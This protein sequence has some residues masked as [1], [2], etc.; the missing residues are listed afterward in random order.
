VKNDQM[1]FCI[2]FIRFNQNSEGFDLDEQTE[3]VLR[4][5][6]DD[7]ISTDNAVED[8]IEKEKL[9]TVFKPLS[10]NS[11]FYPNK[12]IQVN[13][14]NIKDKKKLK[15]I[16]NHIYPLRLAEIL[17]NEKPTK[18]DFEFLKDLHSSLFG[19]IYP[20]AGEVRTFSASKRIVFCQPE[21]IENMSITLFKKL[22]NDR[23]LTNKD[24]RSFINDLAYYMGEMEALHP[25]TDG[26]G[27]AT[28]IFFHFLSLHA[29]Y[30]IQWFEIDPDD[31]LEADISAIDGEYQ[32]LV[33][34]LNDAILD[35]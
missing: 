35:D 2:D 24:R 14:F 22:Q 13:Y 4:Q 20:H 27:R 32:L 29:N 25:F 5:I 18:F 26:N 7:E 19:D 9:E 33:D 17:K 23:Y 1:Q 3:E 28:R 6:L 34:V 31:L 15:K 12:S 30:Q 8:Y 10:D 11:V 21:F 16:E